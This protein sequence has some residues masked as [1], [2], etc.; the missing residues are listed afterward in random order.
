MDEREEVVIR[1]E[2]AIVKLCYDG[3]E[4]KALEIVD[5]NSGRS[6]S[7]DALELEVLTRIDR[8]QLRMLIPE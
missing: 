2:F 7:L 8:E 3:F 1:N 4:P 5:I 6:V